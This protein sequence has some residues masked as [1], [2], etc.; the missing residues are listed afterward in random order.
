MYHV[1]LTCKVNIIWL[2]WVKIH[3]PLSVQ[4]GTGYIGVMCPGYEPNFTSMTPSST[5]WTHLNMLFILQLGCTIQNAGQLKN[6]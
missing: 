3:V 4:C 5:K 1:A 2:V 6:K